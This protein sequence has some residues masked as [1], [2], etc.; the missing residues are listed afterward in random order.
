MILTMTS[1]P[2]TDET[3]VLAAI[4]AGD[5]AAFG[6]L[7]ERHRRRLH[8][9]CYRMLGSFEDAEDLV[10]ETFLRAWRARAAFEGRSLF[11][12]WLYRV[13]TNAC[14]NVL[15]RSPRR[16]L[17]PDV[18]GPASGEPRESPDWA[19]ELPWLQP[20][21]DFLLESAAPSEAEPD[22]MLVSR[23]TIELAY[24]AAI[25]YLPPR[26]R[27]VLLMRDALGWSARQ[28]AALLET[29]VPSVNSALQRARATLRERLSARRVDWPVP[30]AAPD[31]QSLLERFMQAF[32]QADSVGL[33]QLLREDAR[34]AMPP[35]ML[36]F[37]G[38]PAIEDMLRL[39]PLG[40]QGDFRMVPAPANRQPAAATYLRLTGES[41]YRL[42]ALTVLRIDRGQI[43]DI[44]TFSP[45]LIVAFGLPPVMR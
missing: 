33:T 26:Q 28:V 42:V 6:D 18:S 20:Y 19:P 1:R 12:T 2:E 37:D 30:S 4:R 41:L 15:E 22:A 44:T 35:A 9:H 8:L 36:W 45:A 17:P 21:P 23:E 16:V 14:L 3:L 31:E 5:Q 13:A 11:H 39:F 40:W 43:T 25:Q 24:L 32:E 27:A 10:Q 38:R 34:W 29:S 7:A